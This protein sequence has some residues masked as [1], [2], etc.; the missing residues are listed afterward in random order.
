M[1]IFDQYWVY[2]TYPTRIQ[3]ERG[4]IHLCSHNVWPET[5][6][7]LRNW[8][9]RIDHIGNYFHV[10]SEIESSLIITLFRLCS[11]AA[12]FKRNYEKDQA[13]IFIFSTN[14]TY[15]NLV[16]SIPQKN[17]CLIDKEESIYSLGVVKKMPCLSLLP[18]PRGTMCRGR[19]A[20]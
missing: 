16:Y 13:G 5:S 19:Q 9:I 12:I 7:F 18:L 20:G 3:K 8:H 6:N 17:L 14:Y 1:Y 4:S 15:T 2:L 10:Y 11:G